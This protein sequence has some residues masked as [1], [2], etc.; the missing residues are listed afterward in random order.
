MTGVA[1]PFR[2]ATLQEVSLAA[3]VSTATVSRFLNDRDSVSD[4]TQARVQAAIDR[5]GYVSN[6]LARALAS[7]RSMTRSMP[8]SC[9]N[10]VFPGFQ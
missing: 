9:Q 4:K 1:A 2:K 6:G 3:G 5:L 7:R 8:A 10:F